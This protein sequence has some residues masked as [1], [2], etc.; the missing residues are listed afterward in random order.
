MAAYQPSALEESLRGFQGGHE[1]RLSRRRRAL[2]V[3]AIGLPRP[4]ASLLILMTALPA[5]GQSPPVSPERPWH[6][7]EERQIR[8]ETQRYRQTGL[9]IDSDK[10]YSLAELIDL[11]EAHNP[12]TRVAWE[13]ALAQA[14]ALG[15]ARSELY[16]TVSAVA[17]A[18]ADRYEVPLGS[19]FYRQTTPT[20]Q[21]SLDLNYT[22]FDF[23][24]RR[25]R[26]NAEGARAL[27]V[28]FAFNDVH[29]K[30]I[31]EVQEA[32]YRLLN[33]S[34]QEGAARASLANA[35][36]VQQAAEE[37]LH[38][39]LATLPDVLE[40]RSATAQAQYDLQ[41]VL[42]A[43]EIARG[44]LATALGASAATMIRVQPLTEVPTPE[45]IADS[46]NQAI[47]RALEQRPDLQAEVAGIREANAQRSE[48]RAAFYPGLNLKANPTAQSTWVQQQTLPWGH[49]SDLTGGLELS[50]NW[51]VFDGGARRSRLAQADA[52][53]RGAEAQVAAARDRIEDEVWTAYSNLN[54]AFRQREAASSLLEAATQSYA[55][56]LESYN[57]GVRNLL[58]VTAAQKVL[59]Q[60]RS[61][62]ILARAQVLTAL[63]YLAF[64]AG[65]S[66]QAKNG[67][68]R[69]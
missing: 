39:G 57:Y 20:L 5:L 22:I 14:G 65:D 42:G 38:N 37:R 17:L 61:Q 54:T 49:T 58:D 2:K 36:A 67:S 19:E 32:Y 3:N 29:R 18:G 66:I 35:Q 6:S 30:L 4:R 43:E 40:A 15:V 33:A 9:R 64:R 52:G 63:A 47:G 25:G 45:S 16:P 50:L 31:Y 53:I 10:I 27:A 1:N 55:A 48:A 21:A 41:A 26:I 60:A 68:I 12:E 59:A 51:T 62:D 28:N 11:A 44:D 34:G 8:S 46:V 13:N 24:A 23:G 7:T 56:A 69:P